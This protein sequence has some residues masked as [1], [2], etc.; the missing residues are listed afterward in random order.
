MLLWKRN[1]AGQGPLYGAPPWVVEPDFSEVRLRHGGSILSAAAVGRACGGA[2]R[3]CGAG[4]RNLGR[5]KRLIDVTSLRWSVPSGVGHWP[6]NTRSLHIRSV[7][8]CVHTQMRTCAKFDVRMAC[9]PVCTRPCPVP[10]T[11]RPRSDSFSW[12][13]FSVPLFSD[14]L[15]AKEQEKYQNMGIG[16]GLRAAALQQN[17]NS[18]VPA[19][20][21]EGSL[22]HPLTPMMAA[23]SQSADVNPSYG[24]TDTAPRTRTPRSS[25]ERMR[26]ENSLPLDRVPEDGPL[27]FIHAEGSRYSV[28]TPPANEDDDE[29][30]AEEELDE[31]LEVQGLYRGKDRFSFPFH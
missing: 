18:A 20:D 4:R 29:E 15:P 3:N 27:Q 12:L 31:E 28:Q 25:P 7:G 5:L 1:R 16:A 9:V 10:N 11:G 26:R 21:A 8:Y 23:T 17:R 19:L 14:L 2:M 24:S 6:F 13:L 22:S 30:E